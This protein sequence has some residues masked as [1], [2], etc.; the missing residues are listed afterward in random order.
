MFLRGSNPGWLQAWLLAG[1]ITSAVSEA[2]ELPTFGSERA[3]VEALQRIAAEHLAQDA[4]ARTLDIVHGARSTPRAPIRNSELLHTGQELALIHDDYLLRLDLA[5]PGPPDRQMVFSS[6]EATPSTQAPVL[7]AHENGFWAID[8]R[9]T[10]RG[11]EIV[12]L[13]REPDRALQKR[14]IHHLR[15]GTLPFLSWIQDGRLLLYTMQPVDR[16]QP[17]ESLPA[18]RHWQGA[19]RPGVFRRHVPATRIHY[20]PDAPLREPVL[21]TLSR[22]EWRMLRKQ[23]ELQC[24]ANAV[25]SDSARYWHRSENALYLWVERA[26]GQ[27][28]LLRLPFDGTAPAAIAVS[29]RPAGPGAFHE[30]DG[31]LNILLNPGPSGSGLGL[32]RIARKNFQQDQA[33]PVWRPL[34]PAV[35]SALRWR[36]IGPFLVYGASQDEASNL[37]PARATLQV[38]RWDRDSPPRAF[39][40][41]HRIDAIAALDGKGVLIGQQDED[42]YFT[43]L[44]LGDDAALQGR[45]RREQTRFSLLPDAP[46]TPPSAGTPLLVI[47]IESPEQ[48]PAWLWLQR[49]DLDLQEVGTLPRSTFAAQRLRWLQDQQRLFLLE[50]AQLIEARLTVSAPISGDTAPTLLSR[51]N[52]PKTSAL[53]ELRRIGLALPQ[54]ATETHR[55]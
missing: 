10:Q 13:E 54:E 26:A 6:P 35:G 40:L 38:L 20:Q 28:T 16:Q 45:Y 2:A 14:S 3:L 15:A 8:Y 49:Q 44:R 18:L 19:A 51:L 42:L 5:K 33:Q 52:P 12:R 4:A 27:A 25:L 37:Q 55:R 11:L 23:S 43:G 1:L 50:P 53:I 39:A 32:L 47:G 31:Q 30:F 48:G 17:L 21:H 24:E 36:F 9:A 29:G 46:A 41:P 34:P 7:L 22:C